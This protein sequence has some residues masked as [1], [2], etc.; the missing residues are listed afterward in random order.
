VGYSYNDSMQGCLSSCFVS[1][2]SPCD[3]GTVVSIVYFR[4]TSVALQPIHGKIIL[5]YSQYCTLAFCY[6]HECELSYIYPG[7]D[8][9]LQPRRVK[10]YRIGLK[11]KVGTISTAPYVLDSTTKARELSVTYLQVCVCGIWLGISIGSN[12]IISM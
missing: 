12:L 4:C 8:V 2:F 7:H 3:R 9:K 1:L 5:H 10:L 6:V 11:L